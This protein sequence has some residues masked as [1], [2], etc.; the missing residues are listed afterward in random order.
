VT[1]LTYHDSQALHITIVI[2]ITIVAFQLFNYAC[3]EQKSQISQYNKKFRYK[4]EVSQVQSKEQKGN[5][6]LSGSR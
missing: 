1:I 2:T 6:K 3:I 4:H 5:T